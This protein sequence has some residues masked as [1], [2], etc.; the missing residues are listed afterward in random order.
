MNRPRIAVFLALTIAGCASSHQVQRVEQGTEYSV[1]C[2]LFGW[3]IC[4]AKAD[5]LCR[6]EQ[7]FLAQTEDANGKEM[8]IVCP[9]AH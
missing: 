8:R 2:W 9:D 1:S 5:E 3:H 6:G 7:K 4:Y